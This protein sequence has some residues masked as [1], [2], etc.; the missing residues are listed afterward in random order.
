MS[1]RAEALAIARAAVPYYQEQYE[2]KPNW[3][4][5][6]RLATAQRTVEAL[7]MRPRE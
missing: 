7:E 4:T 3:H 2:A 6:A 1:S 5:E